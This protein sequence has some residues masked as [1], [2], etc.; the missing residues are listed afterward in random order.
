MGNTFAS[1]NA[2][3]L[4]LVLG[5]VEV[6]NIKDVWQHEVLP[7]F[8]DCSVEYIRGVCLCRKD[9]DKSE[10]KQLVLQLQEIKVEYHQAVQPPDVPIFT[11]NDFEFQD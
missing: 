8:Y 2:I 1:L 10:T 5:T 3:E 9:M 6:D 7:K 4:L 11:L